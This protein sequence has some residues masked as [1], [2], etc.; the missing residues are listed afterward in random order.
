MIKIFSL[1]ISAIEGQSTKVVLNNAIPDYLQPTQ[2]SHKVT[3]EEFHIWK[4]QVTS[5]YKTS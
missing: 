1:N 5:I 2:L 4:Q 3:I